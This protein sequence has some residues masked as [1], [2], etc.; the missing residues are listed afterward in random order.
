MK[1]PSARDASLDNAKNW[2]VMWWPTYAVVDRDGVVRA[3]G[4]ST[5]HVEDVVKMILE[6]Q[7]GEAAVASAGE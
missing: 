5:S 4:L 6:E 7:P 1:Y 3:L 2:R